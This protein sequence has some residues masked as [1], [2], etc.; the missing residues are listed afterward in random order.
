[1][2]DELVPAVAGAAAGAAWPPEPGRPLY[3]EV[4]RQAAGWNRQGNLGLV[5]GATYPAA[6]AA[7][8]AAAPELPFLVPGIGAQGGEPQRGAGGR[9]GQARRRVGNQLESRHPHAADPAGAARALR[10]AIN[11][12]RERRAST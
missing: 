8:R 4:A 9:A 11:A 2:A 5:V 1:M 7:V 10:D 3:L 12:A 6:L